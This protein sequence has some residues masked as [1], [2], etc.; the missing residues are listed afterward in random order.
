MSE[1]AGPLDG[2]S[3]PLAIALTVRFLIELALLAGAAMLA[4][5]LAPGAWQWPAA[6]GAGL[7]VAVVWGLLLSPKA[8]ITVPALVQFGIEALLV[9]GVGAGLFV[10][11]LGAPAVIGVLVWLVDRV[12]IALLER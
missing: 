6:I 10:I 1:P 3:A 2:A 4:W 11:G 5:R 12:A 8:A 7:L 9:V